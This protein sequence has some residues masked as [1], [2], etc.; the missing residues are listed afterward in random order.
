MH[1]ESLTL[2]VKFNQDAFVSIS[3]PSCPP[4]LPSPLRGL[5]RMGSFQGHTGTSCHSCN[6]TSESE[7]KPILDQFDLKFCTSSGPPRLVRL[8]QGVQEQERR[9]HPH[10]GV[11]PRFSL[12]REGSMVPG[13]HRDQ[14]RGRAG[15]RHTGDTLPGKEGAE[16]EDTGK[17]NL[18][19]QLVGHSQVHAGPI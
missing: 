10:P 4:V 6:Q 2:P 11:H 16:A 12:C 15:L 14:V 1:F 9:R 8:V 5:Q 19:T 18:H 7:I 3:C 13:L 17:G